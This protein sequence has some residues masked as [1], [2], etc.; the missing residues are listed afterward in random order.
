MAKNKRKNKQK[1]NQN[2]LHHEDYYDLRNTT[3]RPTKH[4]RVQD[5]KYLK[6]AMRG[7]IDLDSYHE[8]N[9]N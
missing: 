5:K 6:D 8:Y 7:D 2:N 3:K 4:R 9:G 1:G